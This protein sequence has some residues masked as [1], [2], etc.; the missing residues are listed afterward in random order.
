VVLTGEPLSV[1]LGPGIM[2]Q[3]FDGI[4]RPLQSFVDQSETHYLE[5]GVEVDPLDR[6]KEWEFTKKVEVGDVVSEGD[7]VGVVPETTIIE[8][9]I[10]VP[11]GISG[12]IKSIEDGTF[13]L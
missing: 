10:M 11:N 9:R 12:T 5:R 7:I 2:A 8:H 4:Q 13:R 3:M 6:E 1:E